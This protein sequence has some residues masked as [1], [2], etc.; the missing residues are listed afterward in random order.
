MERSSSFDFV[1]LTWNMNKFGALQGLFFFS[2][3]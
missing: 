3:I 1:L 2:N